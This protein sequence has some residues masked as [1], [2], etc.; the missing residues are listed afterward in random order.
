[1]S[2]DFLNQ[3]YSGEQFTYGINPNEFYKEQLDNL[4][5]GRALFAREGEYHEGKA[6]AIRFVGV[7][8]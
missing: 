3:R 4:K 7:K 2:K 6:D 5:P 1:M 8:T